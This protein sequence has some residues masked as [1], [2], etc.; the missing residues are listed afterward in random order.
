MTDKATQFLARTRTVAG[1]VNRQIRIGCPAKSHWDRGQSILRAILNVKYCVVAVIPVTPQTQ[2]GLR[3]SPTL[4][5]LH[6]IVG[7]LCRR[8]RGMTGTTPTVHGELL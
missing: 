6:I 8:E 5:I 7:E 1:L 4:T 2:T 3:S